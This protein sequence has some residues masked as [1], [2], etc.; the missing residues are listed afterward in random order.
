VRARWLPL[1]LSFGVYLIPLAGPHAFWFLGEELALSLASGKSWAWF[2]TELGTALLAQAVVWAIVR[3]SLHGRAIRRLAWLGVA[4]V[5]AALNLA[6]LSA[7]PS[8]FLIEP[9]RAPE[10]ITWSEHCMLSGVS[11]LPVR[12]GIREPGVA[13]HVWWGQRPNGS[14]ALIDATDCRVTD[15]NL[16]RPALQPDGRV[17]FTMGLASARRDGAVLVQ[18]TSTG[19]DPEPQWLVLVDPGAALV[20]LETPEG[21]QGSPVL[22]SSGDAVAWL[23]TISGTGPPVVSRVLVRSWR[24]HAA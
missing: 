21:F 22:A 13:P 8:L 4:P 16:P 14:Y 6:F 10:V 15:A 23:Q 9:D 17:D 24:P 12:V 11:L 2:A 7:I 1:L 19:R 3:W 5:A 20:P 18:R